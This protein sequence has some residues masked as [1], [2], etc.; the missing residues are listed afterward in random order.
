MYHRTDP[1]TTVPLFLHKNILRIHVIHY[2]RRVVT[3]DIPVKLSSRSPT[4]FLDRRL[5]ELALMKPDKWTR[6]EQR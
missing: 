4:N 6:V 1:T 5:D 2:V 3:D